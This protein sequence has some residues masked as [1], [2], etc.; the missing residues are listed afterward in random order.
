MNIT[1]NLLNEY[2]DYVDNTKKQNKKLWICIIILILI[3]IIVTIII[4]FI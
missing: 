1:T 3:L 2:V 4:I